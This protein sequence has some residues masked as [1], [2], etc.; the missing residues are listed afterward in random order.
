MNKRLIFI[1]EYPCNVVSAIKQHMSVKSLIEV[2]GPGEAINIVFSLCIGVK[3]KEFICMAELQTDKNV[4]LS[5]S[6]HIFH[7]RN[8][9]SS[10]F[11]DP[12]HI[13]G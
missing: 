9:Y 13:Y 3:S 11:V 6:T 5:S 1:V 8:P 4:I 10:S 7:G 2:F 12:I